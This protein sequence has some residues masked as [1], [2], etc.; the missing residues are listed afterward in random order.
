ML[1]AEG[2]TQA[3]FE[4]VTPFP[5]DYEFTG[6]WTVNGEPYSFDAINQLAA[7]AAAVE[8]GNE[9]KL[10]AALDAAGITYKDETKMP[11]YLAALGEDGATASLEADCRENSRGWFRS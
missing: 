8:D 11:Q 5:E 7:I 2:E 4:F 3:D 1:L 6:V 10:Q 9:V